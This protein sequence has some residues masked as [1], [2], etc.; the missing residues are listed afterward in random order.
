M[1][2]PTVT[3]APPTRR[4]N[5]RST[6][7]FAGALL[8]SALTLVGCGGGGGGGGPKR[9]SAP[10]TLAVFPSNGKA[11]LTWN[12]VPNAT[13]YTVYWDTMP[14][15]TKA[16]GTAIPNVTPPYTH[17]GLTNGTAYYYIVTAR[18]SKGEGLPSAE[19]SALPF[20]G[21]GPYD[22][23]WAS[24]AP[25]NVITLNH[26]PM[27]TASDNGAALAAAI[28]A[29]VPGD[30]L[31]I[32]G[33]T[34]SLDAFFTIDL[35]G[36]AMAPI[37]IAAQAGETPLL[38]RPDDLQN[39]INIGSVGSAR[40][41][42][43]EGLDVMGGDIGINIED[44]QNIWITQGSI[45]ETGG[46]AIAATTVSTS[47]L[48][49]TLNT[50]RDTSGAGQGIV[51]GTSDAVVISN[52]SVIAQ[53]QVYD[54]NGPTAAGIHLN[55][56]S[57]DNWIVENLVH[58]CDWPCILVG[59]TGGNAINTVERNMTYRSDDNLIEVQGEALVQNNLMMNGLQG[60]TSRPTN[61]LVSD[62]TF[63]HNTIVNAGRGAN[64]TG[65]NARPGLVFANNVVYSRDADAVRFVS[66]SAGVDV[67]GN[68]RL[69]PIVNGGAGFVLGT[70]LPDFVNV[71][72]SATSRN[73]IPNDA[74]PII[75]TGDGLY[76]V[77]TDITGA[78]RVMPLEA[79]CFDAP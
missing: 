30:R 32:S 27:M 37:W 79:G 17:T 42:A 33:G 60:F 21:P 48:Y 75:S 67:R 19:T 5:H 63:I 53:N 68:I 45:H 15:V 14:G 34:Y 49:I 73:A 25:A 74:G 44:G 57:F 16:T 56:G 12:L 54:C 39:T 6:R 76:A 8:L 41:L 23:P 51:L 77:A 71:N 65:W 20:A 50:I 66:G 38:T 7:A 46:A 59:G 4:K 69:G 78:A 43:L 70:G 26:D 31:E 52:G 24:V 35:A 11:T 72:W 3:A 18:N 58:D 22:P 40:Y 2:L 28:G 64:L 62:L 55:Q 36:T 1:R 47:E 10:H 9:P 29:L 13:S 61:D